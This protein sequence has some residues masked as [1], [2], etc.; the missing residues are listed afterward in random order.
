MT[1]SR[2]V[3]GVFVPGALGVEEPIELLLVEGGTLLR[4][5]SDGNNIFGAALAIA[6]IG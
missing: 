3:V 5:V 6:G 1:F 4:P 2:G